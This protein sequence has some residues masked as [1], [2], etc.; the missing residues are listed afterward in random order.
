[1]SLP[2]TEPQLQDQIVRILVTVL[3][4]LQIFQCVH[5]LPDVKHF[6]CKKVKLSLYRP[7]EALGV[8]GE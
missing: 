6:K 2:G 7:G 1:M 5:T 4:G 3:T 8:P